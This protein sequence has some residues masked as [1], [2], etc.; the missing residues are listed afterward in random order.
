MAPN[1]S[2]AS[3][4]IRSATTENVTVKDV[5]HYYVSIRTIIL[6]AQNVFLYSKRWLT[7]GCHTS[8]LSP[9]GIKTYT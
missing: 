3:L 4:T 9:S 1:L 7:T 8:P 6:N 2:F 5:Q